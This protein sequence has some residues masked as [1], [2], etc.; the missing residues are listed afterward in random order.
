MADAY[1]RL[2]D[3]AG[4]FSISLYNPEFPQVLPENIGHSLLQITTAICSIVDNDNYVSVALDMIAYFCSRN[5][6]DLEGALNEKMAFNAVREDH[7]HEARL[8]SDGKKF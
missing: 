8:K 7:T 5:G 2:L 1:I 3:Y 4:G 6:L